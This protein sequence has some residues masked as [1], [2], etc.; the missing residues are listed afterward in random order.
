MRSLLLSR[1]ALW[2]VPWVARSLPANFLRGFLAS[3]WLEGYA[4]NGREWEVEDNPENSGH[5]VTAC[6]VFPIGVVVPGL[7]GAVL[8]L[9]GS[10]PLDTQCHFPFFARGYK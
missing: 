2:L 6:R 3:P 7:I 1:H 9:G 8:P 4:M 10:A 5:L